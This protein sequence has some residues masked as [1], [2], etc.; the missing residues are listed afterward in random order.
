[1]TIHDDYNRLGI[2]TPKKL[3]DR[4]I[5]LCEAKDK[6]IEILLAANES[7]L[8]RC[9]S[10]RELI[11]VERQKNVLDYQ[12]LVLVGSIAVAVVCSFFA[13]IYKVNR[14]SQIYDLQT[15]VNRLQ[16]SSLARENAALK[17]QIDSQKCF[18]SLCVK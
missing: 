8:R 1:M 6:D 4:E 17:K 16:Q 18:F 13:I 14:D 15:E 5:Q 7:L 10:N 3:L 2:T 12:Y 11:K 9:E